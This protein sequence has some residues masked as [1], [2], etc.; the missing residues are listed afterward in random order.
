MKELPLEAIYNEFRK[1]GHK[2]ASLSITYLDF[3]LMASITFPMTKTSF[4]QKNLRAVNKLLGRT[5]EFVK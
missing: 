1:L 5:K 3:F 4:S 2:V